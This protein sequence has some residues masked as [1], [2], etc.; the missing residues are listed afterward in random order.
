MRGFG[1]V[2]LGSALLLL[3]VPLVAHHGAADLFDTTRIVEQ[4]G[5]VS[6]WRLVNPHPILRLEIA[7]AGGEKAIW[8]ISF[9]PSAASALRR[10]GFKAETFRIGEMVVVRGHPPKTAGVRAVDVS[11]ADSKVT[12]ANG[13]A[14]P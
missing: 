1:A 3:S 9:G 2:L 13:A 7:E 5:I 6:D 11:G 8:E 12:R 14:V 10:R 4:K